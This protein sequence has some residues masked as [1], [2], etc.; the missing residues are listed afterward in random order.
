MA[1]SPSSRWAED[2]VCSASEANRLANI[3][4]GIEP[5]RATPAKARMVRWNA[6]TN[7]FEVG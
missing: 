2:L 7:T 3:I 4:R 6:E 5:K 1:G